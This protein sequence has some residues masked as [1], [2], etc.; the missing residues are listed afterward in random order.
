MSLLIFVL[1]LTPLAPM[2]LT[3]WLLLAAKF[4]II[5]ILFCINI[6]IYN[7]N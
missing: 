5:D 4:I 1:L 7:Y 6:L 2:G 3:P